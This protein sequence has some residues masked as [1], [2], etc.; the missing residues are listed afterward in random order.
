MMKR[1]LSLSLCLMLLGTVVSHA[2]SD[3]YTLLRDALYRIVL[4]TEAGDT[5]IGSGVLF[6]QDNVLL[7]AEGCCRE[8]NLFAI[9]EDGEHAILLSTPAGS[10]GAALMELATPS[11]A[12]PLSLANYDQQT[13]P[14]I[15][16]CNG[17]GASGA[18]P[19]YQVLY[20]IYRGQNALTLSGE[21]GVLPGA[22]IADETGN[23]VGLVVAQQMEGYGMYT[24]LEP[25]SLYLAL[26]GSTDASAFLPLEVSWDGGLLTISWTDEERENG[27]YL[28]TLS[29]G[30]N[31]YYTTYEIP[32][33][34]HSIQ[35]A[36]PPGHTYYMQAQWADAG[37]QG[38]ELLWN[39]MTS[40][41]VPK[42]TFSQYGFKQ[43]CYLAAAPAGQE[44][45]E[46]L[47]E[48]SPITAAVLTDEGNA[49]YLQVFNTYDVSEEI[50]LPMTVCLTAPDGQIYFEEMLYV[51]MPEAE[52][53]DTFAVPVD[54]LF[55]S[56]RD[57]SGQGKLPVGD[58]VLCYTID[59]KV[60]GEY[61][62]SLNNQ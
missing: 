8:G 29:A 43:S 4:R 2:D 21:E 13:L 9:G 16:G 55:A 62:F 1:I 20:A 35:L 49:L 57:F 11:S 24:A 60:A 38:Q 22:I 37:S 15:F 59:G 42:L 41:T 61:V 18:A 45:T 6:M 27:M 12:A 46:T 36:V 58:Y 23:V 33:E 5:T 30:E 40:Y 52:T 51:F 10:S 47:A 3:P 44:V 25:D 56:C 34:D 39:A 14:Y 31:N 7:T 50:S 48:I 17:E 53:N 32:P 19:L 28:L 26:T 54:G